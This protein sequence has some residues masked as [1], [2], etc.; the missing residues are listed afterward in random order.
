MAALAL[1]VLCSAAFTVA[2]SDPVLAGIETGEGECGGSHCQVRAG[3][4]P[5]LPPPPAKPVSR[6]ST[7]PRQCTYRR[8]QPVNDGSYIIEPVATDPSEFRKGDT[9]NVLCRNPE[10][11]VYDDPYHAVWGANGQ[12]LPSAEQVARDAV[13]NIGFGAA[14][15]QAWPPVSGVV[16]GVK[17]YFQVRN[18]DG[19]VRRAAADTAPGTPDGVRAEL[20]ATPRRTVW[21]L[22]AADSGEERVLTCEGAGTEWR[23]GLDDHDPSLCGATFWTKGDVSAWVEIVYDVGWTSNAGAGGILA[24]PPQA[25]PFAVHVRSIQAVGRS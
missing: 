5:D 1:V 19:L 24:A 6:G 7:A 4:R 17:T 21:H 15:V 14:E 20:V 2:G 16:V 10:T 12:P 11:G 18:W 23:T 8:D 13:D 25:T 22:G 3:E 9:V